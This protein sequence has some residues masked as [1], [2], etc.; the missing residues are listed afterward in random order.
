M[1]SIPSP[2]ALEIECRASPFL[3]WALLGVLCS[4]VVFLS[5]LWLSFSEPAFWLCALADGENAAGNSACVGG[6][7]QVLRLGVTLAAAGYGG[8]MLKR[9]TADPC[10]AQ[11]RLRRHR[12]EWALYSNG[13]FH[14]VLLRWEFVSRYLLIACIGLNGRDYRVPILWDQLAADAHRQL[15][16]LALHAAEG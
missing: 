6:V 11:L 4:C 7:A 8:A 3:R 13:T 9:Y 2:V 1:R 15:R 5:Q 16:C 14:P 12:D 10:Y